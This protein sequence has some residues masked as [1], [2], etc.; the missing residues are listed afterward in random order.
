MNKALTI[1]LVIVIFALAGFAWYLYSG[2]AK[3]KATATELGAQL[4]QCA[5]AIQTCQATLSALQQVP[6]CAPYF[7]AQ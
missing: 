4:Q 2:A 1:I 3:C 6:A 5:T 7:P